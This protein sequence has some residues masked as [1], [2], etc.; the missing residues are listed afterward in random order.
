VI[1]KADKPIRTLQELVGKRMGLQPGAR[2]SFAIMMAAARINPDSVTIVP[3]G[4]D[5]APLI[6][7]QIDGYWGT[8]VNQ[9]ITLRLQGVPNHILKTTEAGVPGYWQMYFTTDRGLVEHEDTLVRQMRAVIRGAQYFKDNPDEIADYIVKRT[10]SLNLNPVQVREA[11]RGLAAMSEAPVTKQKG[12]CWFDVADL[13]KTI[14]LMHSLGQ[15]K[16]RMAVGDTYSTT[17]LEKA[18]GGRTMI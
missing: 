3:I 8:A 7:G 14:E 12:L 5:P 6:A 11:C 13:D 18:Y 2:N 4:I 1:S 10:P 16:N 9:A 17:I 15:I